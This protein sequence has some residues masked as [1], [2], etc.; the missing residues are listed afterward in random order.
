MGTDNVID[1][2]V[3]VGSRSELRRDDKDRDSRVKRLIVILL[4][5]LLLLFAVGFAYLVFFG[6]AIQK[7]LN[8]KDVQFEFSIY[9]FDRPLSVGTDENGL[10][11]VSDTGNDRVLVF[12]KNGDFLRRIGTDKRRER[13]YGALGTVA[14][15]NAVYVADWKL[16][17]IKVFSDEGKYERQFP[18]DSFDEQFG[19]DGFSPYGMAAYKD[20]LYVTSN[21]GIYIFSKKG[22]F[23]EKWGSKGKGVDQ[24][25]YPI[26]IAI[27]QEDGSVYVADQLNRRLKALDSK[28]NIRWT[29]GNPDIGGKIQSFFGL[30]R[31]LALDTE[32]RLYVSDT[33]HNELYVLSKK[34]ELLGV[35]GQRGL[36]DGQFNF[37]EGLTFA[38]DGAMYIAD[39]ENNRIQVIRV[40][41][42]PEPTPEHETKYERFFT[43]A[44]SK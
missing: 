32:G 5:L 14:E 26:G 13:F 7:T 16:R 3:G 28:G 25:D 23:I 6:D 10:I 2:K 39:R 12:E 44:P 15:D 38:P 17:K 22:K 34:G 41:E 35:I 9:G 42:I 18:E 24:Y 29:V 31:G 20:K 37:P 30:P 36:N 4:L 11:Y 21:D 33:F 27:D 19:A 40:N 8:P 43:E 1:P